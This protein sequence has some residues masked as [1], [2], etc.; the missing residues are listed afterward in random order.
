MKEKSFMKERSLAAGVFAR[1]GK[2]GNGVESRFSLLL[3]A[4]CIASLTVTAGTVFGDERP[5]G[6]ELSPLPLLFYTSD[7]GLAG[8]GMVIATHNGPTEKTATTGGET[9]NNDGSDRIGHETSLLLSGTY[10]QKEQGELT[11][12]A[13]IPLLRGRCLIEE[14]C[15]YFDYPSVFYGIGPTGSLEEDYD[16][17]KFESESSI[18]FSLRESTARS[19]SSK[20][21]GR[22]YLGPTVDIGFQHFSHFAA[23]SRLRDLIDRGV[24]GRGG[25][26]ATASESFIGFGGTLRYD[27]RDNPRFPSSGW[28]AELRPTWYPVAG[29]GAGS[30]FRLQGEL[31][32]FFPLG[33]SVVA[34]T[35]VSG[36]ISQGDVP[37]ARMTELG[38]LFLMRGYPAGRYIGPNSLSGQAELRCDVI[39]RL[40]AVVFGAVGTV[41]K[42]PAGLAAGPL[43]YSGGTGV[44][45][46]INRS[47][48]VHIRIDIGFSPEGSAL[49]ITLLEAF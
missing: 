10:T 28:Y 16:S 24:S 3:L 26:S 13:S 1:S 43:K 29:K 40:R 20:K 19:S 8:G 25:G 18:L 23:D 33:R 46:A 41:A 35:R 7:T 49:Y 11:V 17:Q 37:L 4:V 36:L 2:A 47:R 34:A 21:L 38:G 14:E 5:G 22:V 44:R 27:S 48:D 32:T 42:E 39:G 31:K 30:F 45:I 15:S 9:E 6:W 12:G